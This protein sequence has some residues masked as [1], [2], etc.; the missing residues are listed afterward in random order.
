MQIQTGQ[1]G[2]VHITN[3]QVL[4]LGLGL[5]ECRWDSDPP[6]LSHRAVVFAMEVPQVCGRPTCVT[7]TSWTSYSYFARE[8]ERDRGRGEKRLAIDH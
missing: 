4:A 5:G 7:A 6:E 3:L 8:R 2:R 1:N